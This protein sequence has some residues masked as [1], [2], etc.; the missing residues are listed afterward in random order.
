MFSEVHIISNSVMKKNPIA[1]LLSEF[2]LYV[3]VLSFHQKFEDDIYSLK[4][5]I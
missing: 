3:A 4:T 2:K 5:E 1:F